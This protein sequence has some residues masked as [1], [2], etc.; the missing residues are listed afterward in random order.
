MEKL[1]PLRIDQIAA[2]LERQ[3]IKNQRGAKERHEKRKKMKEKRKEKS[4]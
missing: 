4:S 2:A 3:R 1:P